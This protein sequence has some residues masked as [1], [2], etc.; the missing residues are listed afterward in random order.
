MSSTKFVSLLGSVTVFAVIVFLVMNYLGQPIGTLVDWVIGIAML[1]W[2]LAI[3]VIPWNMHFSAKEVLHDAETSR[4]RGI[5]VNPNDVRYAENLAKRFL[6]IAI[7]LHII[8]ALGMY[9][10]AQFNITPLGYIASA[11]AL[12]LTLFRPAVRFY[13][14]VIYRLRSISQQLHYPR[15][16]VYELRSQVSELL[17]DVKSLKDALDAT[18]EDSWA[19]Q[20]QS[21]LT[22]LQDGSAKLYSTLDDLV[23]QNRREHELLSRKVTEDIAALSED[24]KFLNQMRELIRFFK[25]A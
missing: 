5:T 11:A 19:A 20:Q 22:R 18:R 23:L 8:T 6:W 16:D 13:E 10:L 2:L 25:N 17:N 9:L 4:E 14:Y 1:W 12:L 15:E 21:Q 7:G 24:A 3:V